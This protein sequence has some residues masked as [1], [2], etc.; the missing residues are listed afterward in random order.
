MN[1]RIA[2]WGL[3]G[4]I[5]G[6][7]GSQQAKVNSYSDEAH[8]I[9]FEVPSEWHIYEDHDLESVESQFAGPIY[10]YVLPIAERVGIDGF[11]SVNAD[12][13]DQRLS[14]A[15][16]PIGEVVIRR[17]G[18]DVRDQVS[19][20][21]VRE[22]GFPL[23]SFDKVTSYF[24]EDLNL[25]SGYLGQKALASYEDPEGGPVGAV[26]LAAVSDASDEHIYSIAV[27][28]SVSCFNENRDAIS[29]VVSSWLVN[30]RQ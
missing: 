10:T 3:L 20:S 30:V 22:A 9:Y 8:R 27:G 1:H 16:F 7:C 4:L 13:L 17:V 5:L 14:S 15:Q 28:C 18:P 12:N 24:Q 6:A 21:L 2:F 11:P 23:S 26:Y 19:R 25:G 29:K